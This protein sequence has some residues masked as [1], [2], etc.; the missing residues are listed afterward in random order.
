MVEMVEHEDGALVGRQPLERSLDRI[1][2][3]GLLVRSDPLG[4]DRF[5]R[6]WEVARRDL[7]DRTAPASAQDLTAAVD[8]DSSQPGFEPRRIPQLPAV[9]PGPKE[10]VLRRVPSVGLVTDDGP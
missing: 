4:R 5:D 1:N 3:H 7:P 8:E 10:G 6:V 2:P 9:S